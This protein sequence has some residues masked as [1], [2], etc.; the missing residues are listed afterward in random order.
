M[1]PEAAAYVRYRLDLARETL[2]AAE[3]ALKDGHL[4][5]AVNRQYYACF[6]IVSALLFAEGYASSKHSGIRA[7]FNRHWIKTGRLPQDLSRIYRDQFQRR[8]RGD[9]DDFVHF[10]FEEV[11]AWYND[12]EVF[13]TL[14]LR[15]IEAL[16]RGGADNAK[17]D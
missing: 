15:E 1:K 4:H 16:L 11:K 2:Q 7:L 14:I 9:Y 17:T 3:S 13:T 8:Q 5:S 12:V 6:Y 10:T